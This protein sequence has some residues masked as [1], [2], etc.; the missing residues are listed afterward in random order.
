LS[1]TVLRIGGYRFYFNSR[2]E[3]RMHVHVQ[4]AAGEAKFWIEP[5]VALDRAWKL[6]PSELKK[7]QALIEE[8]RDAIARAWKRHFQ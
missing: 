4:A 8:N 3:T 2:E 5:I 1:P 7:L 6:R